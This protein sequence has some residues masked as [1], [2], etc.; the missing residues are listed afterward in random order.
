MDSDCLK[1][2]ETKL[3]D[4]DISQQSSLATASLHTAA[5]LKMS[6][7]HQVNVSQ[8]VDHLKQMKTVRNTTDT[9]PQAI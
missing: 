3:A 5:S 9:T 2:L 1:H 7:A 8:V 6:H 4:K